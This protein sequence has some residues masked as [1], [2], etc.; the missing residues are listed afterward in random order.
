MRMR[1]LLLTAVLIG[2]FAVLMTRSNTSFRRLFRPMEKIGNL[3]SGPATA[4]GAGLTPDELNNIEIYKEA[5]QATVYITSTVI[6][7]SFFWGDY[8]VKDLG[9][10]FIINPEGQILTNFHV[11]SGSSQVEVTLSGDTKTYAAKI[12]VPDRV[13]DLALIQINPDK[14]L[15]FLH[16]GDSDQ[17]QVG[18]K[19]LAIGNPFGLSGTL[20]TGVVSS[21]GRNIQSENGNDM[22]RMIQTDA[23]INSG[24]SGGPLLDST[25]DVIGI[26]TAIYGP[27]GTNVGIGFAMPINRAKRMLADFQAGRSFKP[28]RLGISFVYVTGDLAEALGLPDQGGLLVQ[29]VGSGSGA[30]KAGVR[31]PN[32]S[33]VVGNYRVGLGG[34]LITAIDGQPVEGDDT[35]NRAMQRKRPGDILDLKILRDGKAADVKVT[36]GEAQ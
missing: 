10:G 29:D 1:T 27:N 5:Q 8:P 4:Q 23:A 26:N 35:L 22:E 33:V 2:G 16:L 7:R 15:P 19:V 24:N 36:L 25:G 34:D 21:L 3:W 11:V 13:D 9:S 12:L 32:R 17:L 18:Q 28:A 30:A 31:G 6:Q 20:T 14:K